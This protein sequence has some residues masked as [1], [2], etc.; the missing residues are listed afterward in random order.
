MQLQTGASTPRVVAVKPKV[1]LTCSL[2]IPPKNW[3]LVTKTNWEGLVSRCDI[4]M[5]LFVAMTMSHNLQNEFK[6]L[7]FQLQW[8]HCLT[9]AMPFWLQSYFQVAIFRNPCWQFTQQSF[10]S[11]PDKDENGLPQFF[12]WLWCGYSLNTNSESKSWFQIVLNAPAT[13]PSSF[14]PCLASSSSVNF[15]D[16]F[17]GTS[18][19]HGFA[20]SY[21]RG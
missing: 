5:A 17:I 19:C 14:Q 20:S 21:C 6:S 15:E 18:F 7:S 16:L 11:P 3:A 4:G 10:I 13:F 1:Y 2:R 9:V 8:H 12:Q